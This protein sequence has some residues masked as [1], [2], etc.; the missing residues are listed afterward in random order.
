[1]ST[2]GSL[3]GL[4]A[5]SEFEVWSHGNSIL[6]SPISNPNPMGLIHPPNTI[7]AFKTAVNMGVD[8]IEAD[9]CFSKDKQLIIYHPG[10]L[11]SDPRTMDWKNIKEYCPNMTLF[12]EILNLLVSHQYLKCLLD[13]KENSTE[14]VDAIVTEL[15]SYGLQ[16]REFLTAS[17]KRI[18]FRGLNPNGGL[19]PHA[20]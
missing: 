14:L 2:I 17:R 4:P 15:K 20:K 3:K 19:L 18:K 8:G 13:L 7:G 16:D 10:T 11:K 5:M 1:M 12:Y 9:I 6:R